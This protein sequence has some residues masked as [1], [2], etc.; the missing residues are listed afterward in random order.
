MYEQRFTRNL[1]VLA[2]LPFSEPGSY[3]RDVGR[4]GEDAAEPV[5][6][7]SENGAAGAQCGF[8]CG[9]GNRPVVGGGRRQA[10]TPRSW[11]FWGRG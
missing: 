9:G 6:G 10:R 5:R 7:L 4:L 2:E 11:A 1:P 8:H 3:G